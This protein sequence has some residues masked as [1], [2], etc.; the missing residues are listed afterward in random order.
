MAHVSYHIA[1]RG[2]LINDN[3]PSKF[4]SFLH[5]L[6]ADSGDSQ[7]SNVRYGGHMFDEDQVSSRVLV[8][9]TTP[10][11]H[12]PFEHNPMLQAKLCDALF[13]PGTDAR[14]LSI[15]TYGI[16]GF[17][18]ADETSTFSQSWY[19]ALMKRPYVEGT[20]TFA[21]AQNRALSLSNPR[22]LPSWFK[23]LN[24][25]AQSAIMGYFSINP[26][27]YGN[28]KEGLK[29]A[30]SARG[31][32]LGSKDA[33]LEWLENQSDKLPAEIVRKIAKSN[34]TRPES[35]IKKDAKAAMTQV[36][37]AIA[38]VSS[39]QKVMYDTCQVGIVAQNDLFNLLVILALHATTAF[40]ANEELL[41][42]YME[43]IGKHAADG[44]ESTFFGCWKGVEAWRFYQA[45]QLVAPEGWVKRMKSMLGGNALWYGAGAAW[46]IGSAAWSF[47]NAWRNK[48]Q[49]DCCVEVGWLIEET[50]ART[51][52][53]IT[54]L[55][56]V[57][58]SG[59][60]VT[61]AEGRAEDW[62]LVLKVKLGATPPAECRTAAFLMAYLKQQHDH[63]Q[64]KREELR[65]ELLNVVWKN[66]N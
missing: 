33:G 24:F 41:N 58:C 15:T 59:G 30:I 27:L 60:V 3:V 29:A 10:K 62:E 34:S 26:A 9:F 52:E 7:L 66:V 14:L 19:Q 40:T 43:Y 2:S 16:L 36:F 25:V 11:W 5:D 22:L 31:K 23:V 37:T 49:H 63:L 1:I 54:F 65:A 4:A 51:A 18:A 42:Y 35:E 8:R 21:T 50:W 39:S 47:T 57:N 45:R 53:N 46:S 20:E 44:I 48:Q 32:A 64:E 56:W 38:K 61:F 12:T 6:C 13:L 55:R 17:A 28:S